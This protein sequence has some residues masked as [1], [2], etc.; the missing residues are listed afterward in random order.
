MVQKQTIGYWATA[1][2][3]GT[4]A[5]PAFGQATPPPGGNNPADRRAQFMQQMNDR[6]KT[7]LGLS[8][9]EYKAIQ[10][11]IEAVMTAQRSTRGGGPGGFGGRRGGGNNGNA[12]T[13]PN[14][15]APTGAQA[16]A[17]DLQTTLDNKDAKPEEI[18]A[19]LTALRD[20]RNK[21]K[22]DL[23]KA[24]ADL[25]ELLTQRQEAVLVNMGLLD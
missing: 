12:P 16:A 4:L 1:L 5:I 18:K 17:R 15:P 24:Q 22:E 14:A 11:K 10:P 2:L 9:D 21:A 6:M 23:T 13:D 25:K 3:L 8:D 19:K 20:A 7:Q